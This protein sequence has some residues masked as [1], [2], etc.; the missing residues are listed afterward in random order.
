MGRRGSPRKS[1]KILELRGSWRASRRGEEARPEKGIPDCPDNLT[2]EARIIWADLTKRLQEMG[3]LT[4]IDQKN[5]AL[6]CQ[7]Y[8][9]WIQCEMLIEKKGHTFPVK[10]V[11]GPPDDQKV[12]TVGHRAFPE[13]AIAN[14][15]VTQLAKIG[16][17]FGLSPAS[18]ASLSTTNEPNDQNGQEKKDTFFKLG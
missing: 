14:A 6:Y 13:V 8:A 18:R 10:K 17:E 4:K 5:L 11:V 7:L 2:E 16:K 12:V 9:R 3:V 15:L 1:K